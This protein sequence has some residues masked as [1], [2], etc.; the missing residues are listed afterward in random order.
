M[1]MVV[2]DIQLQCLAEVVIYAHTLLQHVGIPR[3][4]LGVIEAVRSWK[5]RVQVGQRVDIRQDLPIG[6][7]QV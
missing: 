3:S 6:I 5:A 7:D 1:L 4:R 2:G